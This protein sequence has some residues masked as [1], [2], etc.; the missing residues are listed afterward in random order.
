MNTPAQQAIVEAEFDRHAA[1]VPRVMGRLG[2]VRSGTAAE[3]AAVNPNAVAFYTPGVR[4]ITMGADPFS[5]SAA[6]TGRRCSSSGWWTR[7]PDALAG[8]VQS[9][10]HELGHHVDFNGLRGWQRSAGFANIWTTLARELGV[11]APQTR[12]IGQLTETLGLQ[13]WIEANKVLIS[14]M[15]S[16]YGASDSVE[17]LAEVWA[18]YSLNPTGCRPLIRKIGK[19]MQDL[20]EQDIP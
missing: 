8:G 13:T 6:L 7:C 11:A 4:Q 10:A 3:L 19:L 1:L 15:I 9:L 16:T 2:G 12:V 5:V 18:E 17:L 20:A 14:S